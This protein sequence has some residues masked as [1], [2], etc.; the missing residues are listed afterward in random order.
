MSTHLGLAVV[1]ELLVSEVWVDLHL[2]R[3]RLDSGVLQE[4]V[5]LFA[6]EVGNPNG[7]DKAIIYK[8]LHLLPCVLTG[9]EAKLF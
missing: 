8:L 9:N 7:L 3:N 4:R 5:N 2:H 1:H 6:A